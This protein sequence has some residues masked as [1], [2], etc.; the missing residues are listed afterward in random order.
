M[1]VGYSFWGYLT[2]FEN[3]NFVLTPD[4]ERG[5]RVDF[6][7]EML[8]RGHEVI[9]LQAQR[10]EMPYKNVLLQS[11]PK[12]N[13]P[14]VDIAYFEW[15]WP[16]WKNDP[17]IGGSLA[18]EPD[19]QRQMA[20]LRHYHGIGT[21]IIIHDGDLKMT[22]EDELEF[23]NAI[24]ADAC[25]NPKS[26][27]KRRYSLPWCNYLKRRSQPVDYSYNYTYV[28][29]NY[30]RDAQFSKYYSKPSESL[31]SVGI[32]TTVY[33]NW[34]D[35][36]PERRDP[37]TLLLENPYISFGGRLAYNQI[38]DAM[39]RSIAVTHITKD[40][41]TPYGNITGRFMEAIMSGVVA[42]IPKE[43]FHAQVV[44]L[45]DF[46]VNS[47]DDV[48][49]KV[50]LLSM[51]SSK[52]RLQIVGEQEK[53]LRSLIDISPEGRVNFLEKFAKQG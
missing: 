14:D 28:G 26:Q 4:G 39:N 29:N 40:E 27:T 38:F 21:P 36:S 45:K 42:L 3:N 30:E 10:D 25:V 22:P 23:P 12:E 13:F 46:V 2:P 24:I 17:R 52:E 53:A 51:M 16:T 49:E 33:G 50:S 47:H 15:R 6:V 31:R 7:D 20:C 1:R 5:N 18:N 35:R 34:L 44:G 11:D 43:Y 32:Q 48:R 37:S 9:R 41:Y 19:Y 8:L